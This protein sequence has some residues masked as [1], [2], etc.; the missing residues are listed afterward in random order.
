LACLILGLRKKITYPFYSSFAPILRCSKRNVALLR[1]V[2]RALS[3]RKILRK[4]WV[5]YLLPKPLRF[6]IYPNYKHLAAPRLLA[7]AHYHLIINYLREIIPFF[8]YLS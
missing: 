2:F 4:I 3:W 8:C 5:C 7:P 1:P 6:A